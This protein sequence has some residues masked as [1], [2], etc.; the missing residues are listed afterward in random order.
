MHARVKGVDERR[1]PLLSP[2]RTRACAHLSTHKPRHRRVTHMPGE[3]AG[4]GNGARGGA[5][6][7]A[8]A[9]RRRF[10]GQEFQGTE[11][12]KGKELNASCRCSK[13]GA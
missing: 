8:R 6:E 2:S 13:R 10:G 4:A 11:Y 1:L 5:R 3:S 12:R 7:A 9:R